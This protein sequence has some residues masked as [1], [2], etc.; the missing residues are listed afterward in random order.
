[1]HTVSSLTLW[2]TPN[3]SFVWNPCFLHP[4]LVTSSPKIAL[5]FPS[6]NDVQSPIHLVHWPL[7]STFSES[8]LNKQ[9]LSS[10]ETT[11][12]KS[13]QFRSPTR[14]KGLILPLLQTEYNNFRILNFFSIYKD[15]RHYTEDFSTETSSYMTSCLIK[16]PWSL[17]IKVKVPYIMHMTDVS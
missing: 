12:Q 16:P 15:L 2:D 5:N 14:L 7:P 8:L 10:N 11:V 1:M 9:V 17:K 13:Q 3:L 6:S 4:I